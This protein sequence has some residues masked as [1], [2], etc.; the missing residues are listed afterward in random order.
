MQELVVDVEVTGAIRNKGHPFDKRNKMV[1]WGWFNGEKYW[2]YPRIRD[3]NLAN[4]FLI[5]FNL[6]FDLH[7]L[8]RIGVKI[9]ANLRC[10]DAQLAHFILNSQSTPYPSLNDVANHYGLGS[11]LDTV[12]TDYWDKGIDTD[13]VP[14]VILDAYLRRD[15]GLNWEVYLSQREEAER[16]GLLKLIDISNQDLL[17]LEEMEW[18]GMK[19]ETKLSEELGRDLEVRLKIIDTGL[20]HFTDGVSINWD[21]PNQLS[22]FLYGGVV[23]EIVESPYEYTYKSGSRKGT[24]EIKVKKEELRYTLQ[25]LV[26]PLKGSELKKH[27]FFSTNEETLKSLNARGRV[28][29]ILDLLLERGKL[30]KRISTYYHGI[31]KKIK[32]MNWSD[33]ILHGNLNQCVARTGRLSS[34]NPNMQNIDGEVLQCFTSRF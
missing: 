7:W 34:S 27:G 8:R 5:G 15:L 22:A 13:C 12:V 26:K 4:C 10:W 1:L 18:N 6:K 25:R 16:K 21:S 9:P 28:K 32:E 23:K 2:I 29:E 24:T 19:Y 3:V 30:E 11:K 33:N 14:N 17:V 20:S 31:P